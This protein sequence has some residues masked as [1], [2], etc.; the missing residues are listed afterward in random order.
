MKQNYYKQSRKNGRMVLA[1]YAPGDG[2]IDFNWVS[3]NNPNG[4][5]LEERVTESD[6]SEWLELPDNKRNFGDW[7]VL[8]LGSIAP[9]V[10]IAKGVVRPFGTSKVLEMDDCQYEYVYHRD[11]ENDEYASK[12][13]HDENT[14]F[15]KIDGRK[16]RKMHSFEVLSLLFFLNHEDD[17]KK[18]GYETRRKK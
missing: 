2:S 15:Y 10:R 16:R 8:E 17:F 9:L 13:F 12:Y 4:D 14:D 18:N 6:V 3:E 5:V 1:S 11:D 7:L